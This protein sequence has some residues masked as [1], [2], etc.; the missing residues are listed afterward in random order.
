V[1]DVAQGR[2]QPACLEAIAPII[3]EFFDLAEAD[4]LRR[5]E[6]EYQHPGAVVA[7]AWTAAAPKTP[8]DVTRFYEETNSYVFDLAADHCRDRRADVWTPVLDRLRRAPGKDVLVYGDG[9]GTDSIALVR[10]GYRVTYFDLPGIT[11]RFA[12]FRFEREGLA[13]EIAVVDRE[14][15][16]REHSF[17][18]VVSIEVLEHLSDPVG[19]MRLFYSLLRENGVALITESFESVGPDYPSH[20][21]DNF[22][23]AG[24]AHELMESIGF[25]ATYFNTDPINRP[26]EFRRVPSG[27]KGDLIR[28]WGK[29]KRAA[30]TRWRRLA[31]AVPGGRAS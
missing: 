2:L 17:D 4:V 3:A 22:R 12:R 8:D 19:A 9:I 15:D 6:H 30:R 27:W 18:A 29:V 26:M 5:L 11:S 16:L 7:D 23:Y 25:A 31:T 28:T 21:E 13:D 24:R 20:L 10:A 14:D 1:A